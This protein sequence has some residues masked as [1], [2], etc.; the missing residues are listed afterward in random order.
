MSQN[1]HEQLTPDH[2]ILLTYELLAISL[3][4]ESAF[5]VGDDDA[6]VILFRVPRQPQTL[7][8]KSNLITHLPADSV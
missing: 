4:C 3:I 2:N 7:D 8:I 5:E 1:Y 6:S